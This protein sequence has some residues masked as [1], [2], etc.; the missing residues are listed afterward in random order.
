MQQQALWLTTHA[1]AKLDF[2]HAKADGASYHGQPEQTCMR[3][4]ATVDMFSI[5]A[6]REEHKR[7]MERGT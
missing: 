4:S 7:Q 3:K 5:R 1:M 6:P 2:H